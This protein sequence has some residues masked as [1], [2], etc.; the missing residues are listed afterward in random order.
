MK[1]LL[2]SIFKNI[3]KNRIVIVLFVLILLLSGCKS[4]SSVK[5]SFENYYF[6]FKTNGK[7][8][9]N[10]NSNEMN[11]YQNKNLNVIYGL[12]E[13]FD[14]TEI[15]WFVNSI[16]IVKNEIS[17]DTSIDKFVNVNKGNLKQKLAWYKEG[18]VKKLKIKCNEGVMS[19]YIQSFQFNIMT[20]QTIYFTQYFLF[21]K[22]VWYL[23]SFAW[24]NKSDD[25]RFVTSVKGVKCVN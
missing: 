16:V 3:R 5:I 18:E 14:S 22:S 4:Q 8:Y 7:V 2:C 23:V 25:S 13:A 20:G 9:E 10:I 19:G 15:T 12:K 17:S 21:D 11:Q 6:E 1:N 24:D